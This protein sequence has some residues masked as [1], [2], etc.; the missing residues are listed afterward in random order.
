MIDSDVFAFVERCASYSARQPLLDDLLAIARQ[1]GFLHLIVTGVPVGGLKLKPMV[2]LNG[3]PEGWFARYIERD[4]AKTDGVSLFCATSHR[5]FYWKE[6]PDRLSGTLGS[7]LI[8]GEAAEFGIRS[9]FAVPF[10]SFHHW[11]SVA[12]FASP[13]RDCSLS[14]RERVQLVTIATFAGAAIETV[15]APAPE[16]SPLSARETE[17][18]AW[19]ANGKTSWEVGE[20]LGIAE[21]TVKKHA[22]TIRE[23]LGVATTVQAVVE[24]M[25]RR[26]IAL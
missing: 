12:S 24:A 23:R 15:G 26:I 2:A 14:E 25:R 5:P 19:L 21:I 16:R 8:A 11:Q 6:V 1:F 3:W 22:R 10:L 18:L 9:G 4:Y 7:L 20:I 13:A 17:V